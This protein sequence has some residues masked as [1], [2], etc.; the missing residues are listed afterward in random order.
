M[1]VSL[2]RIWCDIHTDGVKQIDLETK[3]CQ[4]CCLGSRIARMT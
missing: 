2:K 4:Q 3:V 1:C